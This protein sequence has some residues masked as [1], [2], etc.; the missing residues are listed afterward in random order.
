MGAIGALPSNAQTASVIYLLG[1]L[2]QKQLVRTCGKG[3]RVR[4]NRV[5]PRRAN[6]SRV[7]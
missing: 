1:V 4:G 3:E 5:Q 6:R 2:V 7:A